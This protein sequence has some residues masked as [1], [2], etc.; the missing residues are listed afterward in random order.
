MPTVTFLSDSEREAQYDI[1]GQYLKQARDASRQV[2]LFRKTAASDGRTFCGTKDE[3]A[4]ILAIAAA[5][6]ADA[7]AT[8]AAIDDNPQPVIDLRDE[9][10]TALVFN[11][12]AHTI[13]IQGPSDFSDLPSQATIRISGS[14]MIAD[15][16]Y[17]VSS[18]SGGTLNLSGSPSMTTDTETEGRTRITWLTSIT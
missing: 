1:A 15:G 2:S 13:Q 3:L 6:D 9:G 18:R 8:L 7:Q 16:E 14:E 10:I 4:A 17:S 5:R 12:T 11:G